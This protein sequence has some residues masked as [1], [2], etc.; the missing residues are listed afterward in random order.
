MPERRLGLLCRL[1][2]SAKRCRLRFGVAL[3]QRSAVPADTPGG[4]TMWCGD[5]H[6]RWREGAG[7]WCD[8]R[9]RR[10]T[11]LRAHHVA[12]VR[13]AIIAPHCPQRRI[14]IV[15]L[16]PK[17]LP[18]GSRGTP[19]TIAANASALQCHPCRLCRN[20]IR[21]ASQSPRRPHC[22]HWLA[23]RAGRPRPYD[24]VALSALPALSTLRGV[25]RERG[26]RFGWYGAGGVRDNVSPATGIPFPLSCA[27]FYSRVHSGGSRLR[28]S[29]A[30]SRFK[31]SAFSLQPSAL[32]S[33]V[34]RRAWSAY[35]HGR[36]R[37]P[38]RRR[39]R[40]HRRRPAARSF[41]SRARRR[42]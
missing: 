37:P 33:N 7:V 23:L 3:F 8:L 17:H 19:E 16:G 41:R 10:R 21:A 9:C 4:C 11:T 15:D 1:S 20:A 22:H 2:A 40:R 18:P 31:A 39:G 29:I 5:G 27:V 30:L 42:P 6:H 34:S 24:I 25:A 35:G 26:R 28:P 12:H 32:G 38:W 36:S 14:A 13:I